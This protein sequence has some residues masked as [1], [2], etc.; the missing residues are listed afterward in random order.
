L[1]V[2]KGSKTRA[3]GGRIHSVSRVL[4]LKLRIVSRRQRGLRKR[5]FGI[6]IRGGERHAQGS[7]LAHGM[8]GVGA[9]IHDDL[10]QL[11]R[12]RPQRTAGLPGR[13][14]SS[15]MPGDSEPRT[16]SSVSA[17][18]AVELDGHALAALAA[19]VP[20]NLLHQRARAIGRGKHVLGVAPER[21]AGRGP[22]DQHL[23]VAEDA[24]ED[25][26]EVVAMP[27]ARRPTAS[28]F[29]AW[30][31]RCSRRVRSVSADFTLADVAEVHDHRADA[32]SHEEV[33]RGV[34]DPL[35]GAVRGTGCGLR[36]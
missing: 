18:I 13:L 7:V 9:E 31:S 17:T 15:R 23:D 24:A 28:I 5:P 16:S 30:R 33:A 22:F 6:Q 21:R 8:N 10:V 35:P 27:P 32:R 14:V 12:G 4:H 36:S 26:V 19:A 3:R 29:S 2:K 11:G 34:L 1:V 25:V 20:E